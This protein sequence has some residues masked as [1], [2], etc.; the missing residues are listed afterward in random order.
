M[1]SADVIQI[2]SVVS[3]CMIQALSVVTLD[4]TLILSI[5]TPD[6]ILTVRSHCRRDLDPV[7]DYPDVIQTMS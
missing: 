6:T 2:L 4:V 7:H 1:V 3:L 5:V